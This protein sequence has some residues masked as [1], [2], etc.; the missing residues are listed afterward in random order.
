MNL[1]D[2]TPKERY[3]LLNTEIAKLE[4]RTPEGNV[5]NYYDCDKCGRRHWSADKNPLNE[6][7]QFKYCKNCYFEMIGYYESKT[8]KYLSSPISLHGIVIR[9][10]LAAVAVIGACLIVKNA[11]A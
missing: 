7:G 4:M 9:I 3:D 8:A 6:Y 1:K 10:L 11:T 5:W 2:L